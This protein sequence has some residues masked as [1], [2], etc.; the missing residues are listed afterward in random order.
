VSA[1]TTR[2]MIHNLWYN[3]NYIAIDDTWRPFLAT[4]SRPDTDTMVLTLSAAASWVAY[5]S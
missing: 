2:T 4:P 1:S 3:P 5:L